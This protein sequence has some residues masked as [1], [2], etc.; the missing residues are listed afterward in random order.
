MRLR[1]T[2]GL[3][4]YHQEGQ[5]RSKVIHIFPNRA[6]CKRLVTALAM[7]QSEEWLNNHRYL[8]MQVFE[9]VPEYATAVTRIQV[10]ASETALA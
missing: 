4:P 5:R 8:D 3:E 9:D 1:T 10:M 7:E 2:N 6:I